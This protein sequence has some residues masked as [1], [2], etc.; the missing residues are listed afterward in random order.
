MLL[1]LAL[2][3]LILGRVHGLDMPRR[4]AD[5][6]QAALLELAPVS[7]PYLDAVRRNGS[8]G[9]SARAGTCLTSLV[10]EHPHWFAERLLPD[11]WPTLPWIDMLPEGFPERSEVQSKWLRMG[12]IVVAAER[13]NTAEQ[14]QP[15]IDKLRQ[16]PHWQDYRVGTRLFI[17]WK[18]REGW[19]LP[20]VQTLLNQMRDMERDWIIEHR[21]NYDPPLLLP[22]EGVGPVR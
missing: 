17:A 7:L 19:T 5:R 3:A 22:G 2:A 8:P 21:N 14:D 1:D 9:A 13:E 20:R 4:H 6:H 10:K 12:S 18:L 15:E 16:P 11:N